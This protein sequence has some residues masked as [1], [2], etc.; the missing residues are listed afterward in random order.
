MSDRPPLHPIQWEQI[1]LAAKQVDASY[2]RELKTLQ[3]HYAGPA[4]LSPAKTPLLLL[5]RLEMYAGA[6]F[7]LEAAQ[8]P[9]EN[10]HYRA[11]LE[12]LAARIMS[13]VLRAVEEVDAV[14]PDA[15]L[16]WH[17]LGIDKMRDGLEVFFRVVVAE[18]AGNATKAPLQGAMEAQPQ[19]AGHMLAPEKPTQRE[20][21]RPQ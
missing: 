2:W 19:P 16:T 13:R 15:K 21:I 14:S 1:E 3:V 20:K 12:A 10:S 7:R 17:S 11:W 5:N 6:L 8:Y 18:Y 9:K 4:T